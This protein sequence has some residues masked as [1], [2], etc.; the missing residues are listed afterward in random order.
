MVMKKV[1]LNEQFWTQKYKD[2]QMGWD[3]GSLSPPIQYYVD[4]LTNKDMAIL[5]PGAGNAYEAEYLFK[6]GFTKV[7]VLDIFCF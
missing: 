2:Q 4:Q 1:E 5:I 7:F 6:Q 3:L